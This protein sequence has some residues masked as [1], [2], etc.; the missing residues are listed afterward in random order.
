MLL[1]WKDLFLNEL[2]RTG[3]V[4]AA[5]KFAK[6]SRSTVY[7]ARRA[8]KQF[9]QDWQEALHPPAAALENVALELA[10]KKNVALLKFLLQA[11]KPEMYKFPKPKPK[12][13]YTQEQLD[14]MTDEEF[15]A[16]YREIYGKPSGLLEKRTEEE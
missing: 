4:R 11:L 12:T 14:A 8:N 16:V 13:R 5:C 7:R 10:K 9:R 6:V 2:L 3:N 1:R 15:D